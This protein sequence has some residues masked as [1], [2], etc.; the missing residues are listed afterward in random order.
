[1]M[2]RLVLALPRPLLGNLSRFFPCHI[3]DGAVLGDHPLAA[4]PPVL[5]L[6]G[7][8]KSVAMR[9][10]ASDDDTA[11]F[12][13]DLAVEHIKVPFQIFDDALCTRKFG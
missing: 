11:F 8:Q 4:S 1:M 10:A 13:G 2:F 6:L 5:N 3:S 9:F 7:V 12:D